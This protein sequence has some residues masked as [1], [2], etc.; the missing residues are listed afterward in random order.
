MSKLNLRRYGIL[1]FA[2]VFCMTNVQADQFPSKSIRIITPGPP[3]G[4]TDGTLRVLAAELTRAWGQTVIVDNKPGGTGLI[5]LQAL[6]AAPNDGHVLGM[7]VSGFMSVLPLAHGSRY[8]P[9]EAA[10]PISFLSEY[11]LVL[12]TASSSPFNTWKEFVDWSKRTG[13]KPSYGTSGVGGTTHMAGVQ[14]KRSTGVDLQDIPYKGDSP[15]I[16]DVIGKQI[17]LGMP[18][19]GSAL[20]MIRGGQLKGIAVVSTTRVPFAPDIATLKE[21]GVDVVFAP[22]NYL[23]GPAQMDPSVVSRIARDVATAM[24]SKAVKDFYQSNALIWKDMSREQLMSL[25]RTDTETG[26]SIIRELNIPVK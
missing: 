17:P 7:Q 25:I 26:Q 13:A 22:W 15:M 20:P 4:I 12:A 10:T 9:L 19:I 8:A 2:S 1:A 21:Q 24:N 5:A 16:T 14:I 18:V 3:G 6:M 11:P 23:Q